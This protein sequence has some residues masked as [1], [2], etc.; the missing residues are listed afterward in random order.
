MEKFVDFLQL[1]IVGL[2]VVLGLALANY[3]HTQSLY[4]A[5][6]SSP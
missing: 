3:S 6:D 2:P 1:K 5:Y 4:L